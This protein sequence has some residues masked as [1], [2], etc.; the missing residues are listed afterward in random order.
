MY[1]DMIV[2]AGGG[3]R[4]E[5]QRNVQVAS[6]SDILKIFRPCLLRSLSLSAPRFSSAFTGS[7]KR[8]SADP[9]LRRPCCQRS[10]M[11][12]EMPMACRN[13]TVP[14]HTR[15]ESG[16]ASSPRAVRP[17]ETPRVA[18]SPPVVAEGRPPQHLRPRSIQ[19]VVLFG[20][21]DFEGT[22]YTTF[23]YYWAQNKP[24]L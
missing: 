9:Q 2:V 6:S 10:P 7:P 13:V 24:L 20:A 8:Q 1:R 19:E 3:G 18:S 14:T 21:R 15:V 16:F 22:E 4:R 11:Y 17:W 5:V 12:C 23:I